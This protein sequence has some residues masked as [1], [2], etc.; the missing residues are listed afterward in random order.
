MPCGRTVNV[1]IQKLPFPTYLLFQIW[2]IECVFLPVPENLIGEPPEHRCPKEGS[3]SLFSTLPHSHCAINRA[4]AFW[5]L[6]R[7]DSGYI[8]NSPST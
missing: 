4:K 7:R 6:R 3:T 1:M 8:L 2:K 5:F